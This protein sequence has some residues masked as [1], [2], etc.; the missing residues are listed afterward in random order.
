VDVDGSGTLGHGPGQNLNEKQLAKAFEMLDLDGSGSVD[1]PEFAK[2]WQEQK[3]QAQQQA[4]GTG[5]ASPVLK[6]VPVLRMLSTG[7]DL[8]SAM[9]KLPPASPAPL[10]RISGPASPLTDGP[11][12]P[13]GTISA[14]ATELWEF[15]EKHSLQ[16]YYAPIVDQLG[17]TGLEDLQGVDS[18]DLDALG[19]KKL[20]KLRFQ[21]AV[22]SL[23]EYLSVISDLGSQEQDA[24]GQSVFDDMERE[25][26]ELEQ[27]RSRG[28]VSATT[29]ESC[30]RK[31]PL[32]Q[33]APIFL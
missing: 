15:L 10:R 13:L 11:T 32:W 7:L 29:A 28:D 31:A 21:K 16:Q 19:F 8:P 33:K 6:T 18:D 30:V 25:V 12:E 26:A 22:Q 17:G 9:Q 24:D 23:A 5:V 2:W 20:E 1:Y 3:D 27:Q 14:E 4:G